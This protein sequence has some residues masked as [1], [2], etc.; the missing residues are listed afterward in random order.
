MNIIKV[1][2][3]PSDGANIFGTGERDHEFNTFDEFVVWVRN[4]VCEYCLDDFRE[5]ANREPITIEDWLS[6]GCGCELDIEDDHD[7]IDWDFKMNEVA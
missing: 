7:M 5:Y 4:Y 6:M 1:S 2:Y 3:L